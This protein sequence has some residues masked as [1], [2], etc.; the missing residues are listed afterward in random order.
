VALL[1]WQQDAFAYAEGWDDAGGRY[2]GL[3]AGQQTSVVMDAQSLVV[4]P[5]VAARQLEEEA[6]RRKEA[7]AGEPTAEPGKVTSEKP[8]PHEPPEQPR[9]RRFHGSVRLD[10][11]RLPR[12]ASQIADEIV[13]H[14]VKLSQAEVE[15]HL[16]IQARIPDGAPDDI[17]RAV[18]ENCRTLK[19]TSHGFEET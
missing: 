19:F 1:T 6:R 3:R 2:R 18:T 13:Q 8:K 17:V 4:K 16:E 7:E 9:L 10:P 5:D 12:D 14:L 15:V 11:T